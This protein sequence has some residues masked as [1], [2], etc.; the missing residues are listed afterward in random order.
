MLLRVAM[1]AKSLLFLHLLLQLYPAGASDSSIIGGRKAKPNSRPYMASLQ[2]NGSHVCGG[3]LVRED[4]ILTAGHCF[5]HG[6][7]MT[8]VLGTENLK[9]KK[10]AQKIPVK[11]FHR[12]QINK[13]VEYDFDIML[14][15]LQRNATLNKSV[16][17][18]QLP[19]KGES[20]QDNTT[21]VISGWGKSSPDPKAKAEDTLLDVT[22]SVQSD[23][24]CR[25]LWQIH[26]VK[27]RMM[28]TL[29]DSKGI[30]QGDSGGPLVC[31]KTAHGIA[32]FTSNPCNNGY[33]DVYMKVSYFIPWIQEIMS[34]R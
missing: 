19:A 16:Q 33:P 23:Q 3:F 9:K 5:N 13:M 31:N 18:I 11:E 28:C 10:A 30:C 6:R 14:L 21:C 22:L 34:N 24:A 17:V 15:K 12:H 8:A 32:S 2:I 1:K 7:K 25:K 20:V 27:V 4:F 29:S 26:F